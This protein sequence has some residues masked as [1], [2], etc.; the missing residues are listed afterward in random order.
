VADLAAKAPLASPALTG[1][2]T[3]PTASAGTNTTQLATTAFVTAAVAGAGSALAIRDEGTTKTSAAT[4]IDFVG[5]GVVATNSGTAVTVTIAGGGSS[6]LPADVLRGGLGTLT[7]EWP[8]LGYPVTPIQADGTYAGSVVG[9]TGGSPGVLIPAC[10][11]NYYS[12][13][14]GTSGTLALT[15]SGG[16]GAQYCKLYNA[17][18]TSLTAHAA[19]QSI[20]VV[21]NTEYLVEVLQGNGGTTITYNLVVATSAGA[22]FDTAVVAAVLGPVSPAFTVLADAAT[23]SWSTTGHPVVNATLTI[24]GNR[25]LAIA[26]SVS[27]QRGTLLLTQDGTGSRTLTLPSGSIKEAGFALSTAAGAKDLL[28]FMFDGTNY[29]WSIHKAYA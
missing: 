22:T 21:A 26:G 14:F 6:T 20:S 24:G 10:R 12:L 18:G 3:A 25:T 8:G 13:R 17:A 16:S 23:V 1:T 29:W 27:G 7:T 4:S 15:L 5:A 2:P 28:A 19:S 9:S 11:A